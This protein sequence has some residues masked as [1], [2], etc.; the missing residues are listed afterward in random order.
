MIVNKK[1]D[2]LWFNLWTCFFSLPSTSESSTTVHTQMR[3]VSM[4]G[5]W[6]WTLMHSDTVCKPVKSSYSNCI[7]SGFLEGNLSPLR[8][9]TSSQ[10]LI[11]NSARSGFPW[12]VPG[13]KASAGNNLAS[14]S[15][16]AEISCLLAKSAIHTGGLP[17][18]GVL[19]ECCMVT[20]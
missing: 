1:L 2:D 3:S 11:V 15:A 5:H 13:W 14:P 4:H 9:S 16:T 8:G 12:S 19:D 20:L 17:I 6:S 10:A 18:Y 7:E